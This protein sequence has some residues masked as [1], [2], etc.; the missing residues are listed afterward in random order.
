MPRRAAYPLSPESAAAA[1]LRTCCD[2]CR[3][4]AAV[5]FLGRVLCGDCFLEATRDAR[6]VVVVQNAE[7]QPSAG[8]PIL[9]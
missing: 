3:R 9:Q 5:Q 7:R 6:V 1:P 2:I 4:N 8:A